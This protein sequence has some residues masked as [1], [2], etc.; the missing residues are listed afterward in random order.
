MD[1]VTPLD[2]TPNALRRY[3]NECFRGGL[4]MY[5]NAAKDPES[6][7]HGLLEREKGNPEY[8]KGG[9]LP[10]STFYAV[11]DG[12]IL[13]AL[14]LRRG[15]NYQVENIIGHIGYEVRPSARGQ[16]VARTLLKWVV[17]NHVTERT[18]ISVESVNVASIKVIESVN[19]TPLKP[20]VDED[21]GTIYRYEVGVN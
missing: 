4:R 6:Y 16:G 15:R 8:L 5:I 19:A 17:D 3:A 11:Q 9:F 18:L 13:G 12:E 10:C 21:M 1:I 2:V 20:F 14:R 7:L